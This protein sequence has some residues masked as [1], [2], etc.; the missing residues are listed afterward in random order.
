MLRGALTSSSQL[1]FV[2]CSRARPR[3]RAANRPPSNLNVNRYVN[4]KLSYCIITS[5]VD[6]EEGIRNDAFNTNRL[7]LLFVSV[8]HPAV[9]LRVPDGRVGARRQEAPLDAVG[10][11]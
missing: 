4:V 6:S 3:L 9:P 2:L 8:A 7:S 10:A 5:P 1:L 11:A